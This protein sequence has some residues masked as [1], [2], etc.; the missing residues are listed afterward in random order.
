MDRLVAAGNSGIKGVLDK[1]SAVATDPTTVT[2]NLVSANGN[3]PYLVSVFNAQSLI[4]PADYVQGTLLDKQ[5]NGTGAWKIV[6]ESYNIATGAKFIRN[7]A[8]WGGKTPLDST[9]YTF[10]DDTG[11]DG[12]R[13]PGRSD[14]RA[15]PVRRAVRG[16]AVHRHELHGR[17]HADHQ[18]P[19]DLDAHERGQFAEKKI[20]QAFALSLD[21]RG[22]DPAAVQGQGHPGQ[23]P[24]DLELLPVLQRH[25]DPADPEHRRWPSSSCRKPACRP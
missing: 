5:P 9:E 14:R 15:G 18:S 7:D 21:R 19:P 23:R 2:M 25:R 16:P 22:A 1:G 13:L 24:R 3:F 11:L 10:F 20:R 12:H 6:P 8:W 17:R 4:T